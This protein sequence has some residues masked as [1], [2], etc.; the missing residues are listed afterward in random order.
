[1]RRSVGRRHTTTN[2]RVR[3]LWFGIGPPMSPPAHLA[4]TLTQSPSRRVRPLSPLQSTRYQSRRKQ[5]RSRP[6][7]AACAHHHAKDRTQMF[8]NT[9]KRAV[10]QIAYFRAAESTP[11]GAPVTKFQSIASPKYR[12]STNDIARPIPNHNRYSPLKCTSCTHAEKAREV[13]KELRV[14]PTLRAFI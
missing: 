5:I 11:G 14:T 9:M 8:L 2:V 12:A 1:M 6:C 7:N 3:L 4:S 13:L 10:R